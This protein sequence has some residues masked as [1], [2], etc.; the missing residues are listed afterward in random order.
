MTTGDQ[1][2]F[3]GVTLITA[4]IVSSLLMMWR[5]TPPGWM[6]IVMPLLMFATGIVC[7]I[8]GVDQGEASR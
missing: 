7:V 8:A 5:H 2:R 4:A 1:R 3:I 6:W